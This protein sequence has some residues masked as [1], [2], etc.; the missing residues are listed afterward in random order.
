MTAHGLGGI[1]RRD[2]LNLG[3]TFGWTSTLLAAG[4]M[5][6]GLT[7]PRLAAA[8]RAVQKKREKKSAR[9]ELI[10]GIASLGGEHYRID[11]IGCLEFVRDLEARTHGE[12]RIEMI[13]RD[14]VCNQIDCVKRAQKGIIDLYFSSTQNAAGAA[15]YFNL[16][17]FPYLFPSRAAQYYFLYHPQS[18][19]LV[20]EPLIRNHGIRFLFS[21]CRLRGLMMGEKWREKPNIISLEELAGTRIRVTASRLGKIALTLLNIKAVPVPWSETLG[22]LE[23]GMIDGLETWVSAA[24]AFM[25][26]L[27]SQVV[28]LR[29]FS[30]NGHTGMNAKVFDGLPPDLQ[31]AVLESALHAQMYVQLAGEAALLNTVGASESQNPGS[32]F[33]RNRVRFVKLPDGEM[34]K[35]ERICSPEFN[36]EPWEQWRGRLN[37]MAGGIDVYEEIHKIAREIPKETPAENVEPRRWWKSAS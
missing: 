19:K 30:G 6:G 33:A 5:T 32:I 17:D 24:A 31:D 4:A 7:L 25:P 10:Y 26:H 29:L 28:D 12:I 9:V 15:P 3:R 13:E 8:A 16:L 23:H 11:P 14:Q 34:K 37:R 27:I 1:S 35:A 22:A 36:P 18:E 20:R 2:L 21:H